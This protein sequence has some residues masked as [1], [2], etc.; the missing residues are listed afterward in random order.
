[1]GAGRGS[2]VSA[3]PSW[4]CL[5]NDNY[6][7]SPGKNNCQYTAVGA[8]SGGLPEILMMQATDLRHLNYPS[9]IR[10][11]HWPWD[12]TVVGKRS[13]WP[14]PMI[15]RRKVTVGTTKKSIAAMLPLWF[16]R[17]VRQL[18][19]GLRLDL[20]RYFRMVAVEATRPSLASSSRMRGLL[21]VGL[22]L[23]IFP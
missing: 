2:S 10:R 20:G 5:V 18:C 12:R 4:S 13:V 8:A 15:G 23:L 11:L 19:D 16:W 3:L 22:V 6:S 17:K 21:Q 1:M 14:C 9:A 7:S